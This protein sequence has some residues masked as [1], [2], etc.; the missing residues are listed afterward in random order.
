MTG[1][2]GQINLAN[3]KVNK[4]KPIRLPEDIQHFLRGAGLQEGDPGVALPQL[5]N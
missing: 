3:A 5:L 4:N 2:R 1:L